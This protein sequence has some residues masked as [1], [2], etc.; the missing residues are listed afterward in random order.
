MVGDGGKDHPFELFFFHGWICY[1]TI[2]VSI[3][4][5]IC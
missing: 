4:G 5:R 1:L 2:F 3:G